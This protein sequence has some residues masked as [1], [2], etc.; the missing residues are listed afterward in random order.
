MI[1][2]SFL[3]EAFSIP[4]PS[5]EKSLLVGDFIVVSKVHYGARIPITPLSVPFV[6]QTFPGTEVRSYLDWIQLPYWRLPG[7][8]SIKNNDVV[9]FNYP[10]EDEHPVDQRKHYVKRCIAIPHDTLRLEN[11]FVFINNKQL[12]D[13][14]KVQYIYEVITDME[15]PLDSLD[16]WG[17]TEGMRLSKHSYKFTLTNEI[18]EKMCKMKGIEDV[19]LEQQK[20]GKFFDMGFPGVEN[21]PWNIDNLGPIVIPAAGD[22]LTL[23]VDT[24]PLYE[25]LITVYEKNELKVKGD[26]IFINGQLTNKYVVQMDYYFMM[27]DNRHNS[28]DSRFWGFVPEDHIVGKAVMVVLSYDKMSGGL[29]SGRWFKGVD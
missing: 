20:P 7:F 14:E 5:M 27:G 24:L 10:M 17:V 9:V 28:A 15:I 25:R 4:T 6:H 26:S 1:V 18:A 23:T 3:F 16:A 12:P 2:R 19:V 29:R 22:T 21:F 11:G 8:S 13:P